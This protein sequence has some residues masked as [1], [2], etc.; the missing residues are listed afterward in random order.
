[1]SEK[2]YDDVIAPALLDLMNKCRDNG[3][4]LVADVEYEPGKTAA[5]VQTSAGACISI[6]ITSIWAQ[7]FGNFDKLCMTLMK[8]PQLTKGHNSIFLHKIGIEP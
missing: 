5:S 4:N 8:N 6:Q 2:Y 7:S 1:M 3:M